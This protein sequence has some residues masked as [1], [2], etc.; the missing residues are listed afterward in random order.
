MDKQKIMIIEDNEGVAGFLDFSVQTLGYETI[1]ACDGRTA[2]KFLRHTTPAM[3]LLDIYLPD[4]SGAEILQHVRTTDSL[5]QVPVIVLTGESQNLSQE[6]IKQAN[7]T[8]IKPIEYHT[9]SQLII[10]IAQSQPSSSQNAPSLQEAWN[11][12]YGDY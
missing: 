1:I 9:L 7:F 11:D 12:E 5:Q 6:V 4:I 8:L 3:I 2:L 10:R